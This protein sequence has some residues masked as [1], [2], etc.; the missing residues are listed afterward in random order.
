MQRSNEADSAAVGLARVLYVRD[1]YTYDVLFGREPSGR[2]V[3]CLI[4]WNEVLP[5][6]DR[7][8]IV[9]DGYGDSRVTAG[10]HLLEQLEGTLG[11]IHGAWRLRRW[12]GGCAATGEGC[13]GPAHREGG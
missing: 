7:W 13:R 1:G 8:A 4:S 11:K 3:A 9:E 5:A 12:S 10:Q 2:F 6:K